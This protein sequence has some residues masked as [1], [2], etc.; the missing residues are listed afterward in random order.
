LVQDFE[1]Y[2]VGWYVLFSVGYKIT[3]DHILFLAGTWNRPAFLVPAQNPG[4]DKKLW[5]VETGAL[6]G[7]A[8]KN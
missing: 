5:L 7:L 4:L 8:R 3:L 1:I 2:F 6:I